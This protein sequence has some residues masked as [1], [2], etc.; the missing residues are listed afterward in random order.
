M[1]DWGLDFADKKLPLW[2]P[3]VVVLSMGGSLLGTC[4]ASG[5][6][7]D[8]LGA[9]WLLGPD[10]SESAA[11]KQNIPVLAF[12][13][14]SVYSSIS[15]LGRGKLLSYPTRS[16]LGL[17][18]YFKFMEILAT[19][20]WEEFKFHAS[21]LSDWAWLEN[22]AACVCQVSKYYGRA[23]RMLEPAWEWQPGLLADEPPMLALLQQ[24][25]CA[26]SK[27]SLLWPSSNIHAYCL[28]FLNGNKQLAWP[29]ELP[30]LK[31]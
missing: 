16:G 8:C 21:K 26:Q 19:V 3:D 15:L 7:A 28:H 22:W 25:G 1:I 2:I 29:M 12:S 13:W 24:A 27:I 31:S 6:D 14:G 10:T 30:F 9:R 20:L 17:K 4:L 5:S 11:Y 23:L 18:M